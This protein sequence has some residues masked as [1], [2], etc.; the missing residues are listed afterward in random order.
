M[1]KV[2]VKLIVCYTM[3]A[4]SLFA[5]LNTFGTS[6]LRKKLIDEKM[7]TLYNKATA[8]ADQYI[9]NYYDAQISSEEMEE[10]LMVADRLLN[11]RIWVVNPKGTVVIDTRKYLTNGIINVTELDESFFEYNYRKNLFFEGV[12]KEPMISVTGSAASQY[13]IKGYICIHV[14]MSIVDDELVNYMDSANISILLFFGL[15]LVVFGFIYFMYVLPIKQIK[16]A[17]IEYATGNFDYKIKVRSH[18]EFRDLANTIVYMAS[19]FKNMDDYQKRFIANISHDFRSPLTSIKGYAEAISDG[20]IPFEIQGKY[21]NIILFETDRLTKLTSTLLEL[22]QIDAKAYMLDI[23]SFDIN[24]IIK[25]TAAT[26]ERTCTEKRMVLNLEFVGKELFVDADMGKIQ[27]VLY[28]L[29]DNAIK[30]SNPENSVRVATEEKGSKAF[31]SIKDNGVGIPKESIKKIWDRFYKS[32]SSRGKDKR[33]TG[34]GL[35]IVKEAITTHNENI[36]VISTEGVGTEF[37]F[38]LPLTEL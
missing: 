37:I 17:V 4:V 2:L 14:P 15:L 38:T 36:N 8:L 6:L 28:N 34:L 12:F 10:Q 30:F 16:T 7:Y 29:I 1:S 33:G 27:Q 19:E 35:S 23:T 21:L 9:A 31:I 18:D 20:T 22:N 5:L 13:T 32:D 3:A 26:F 25:K 24:A 11:A